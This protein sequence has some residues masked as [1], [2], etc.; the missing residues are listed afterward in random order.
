MKPIYSRQ[1]ENSPKLVLDQAPNQCFHPTPT[2]LV[3]FVFFVCLFV[4]LLFFC[5]FFWLVGALPLGRREGP[6]AQSKG[7]AGPTM[8][9]GHGVGDWLVWVALSMVATRG[10]ERKGKIISVLFFR[11][12]V[13]ICSLFVFFCYFFWAL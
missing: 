4:F 13:S 6:V 12:I 2:P 3:F 1:T 8:G 9:A 5:F 7:W 10:Y 11:A